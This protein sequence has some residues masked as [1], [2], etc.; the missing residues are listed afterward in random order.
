MAL[1]R[2]A[3]LHAIGEPMSIDVIEVPKPRP[4]DVLVSAP[5]PERA[6]RWLASCSGLESETSGMVCCLV[7]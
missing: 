6:E 7:A 1:M 5:P 3:R 4:T 2:A